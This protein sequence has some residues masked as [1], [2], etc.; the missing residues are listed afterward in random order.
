MARGMIADGRFGDAVEDL[1]EVLPI[2]K[3][4]IAKQRRG[5]N[6]SE[7]HRVGRGG[8][9]GAKMKVMRTM[10]AINSGYMGGRR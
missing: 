8:R 1:D 5:K 9:A 10:R 2:G 7:N 3:I 6:S 4:P